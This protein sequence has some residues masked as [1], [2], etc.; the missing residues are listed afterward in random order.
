MVQSF[1]YLGT[2]IPWYGNGHKNF[3]WLKEPN[4]EF[5]KDTETESALP[6]GWIPG[7]A[8]FQRDGVS[9]GLK[10]TFF[11]GILCGPTEVVPFYKS[12]LCRDFLV[13]ISHTRLSEEEFEVCQVSEGLETLR[14]AGEDAGATVLGSQ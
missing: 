6:D 7:E 12:E 1:W 5:M 9:Q 13:R 10:P 8:E 2:Y 4:T 14:T 3:D 11:Y